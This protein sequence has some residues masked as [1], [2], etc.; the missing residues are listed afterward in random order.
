VRR[1]L[2]RRRMADYCA[3]CPTRFDWDCG[4]SPYDTTWLIPDVPWNRLNPGSRLVFESGAW[5][6]TEFGLELL[7]GVRE[8][9]ERYKIPSDQ[10][11]LRRGGVYELPVQV[12]CE[13]WV[14]PETFSNFE[15]AYKVTLEIHCR[16]RPPSDG[17]RTW[18][19][20]MISDMR[21]HPE[22]RRVPRRQNSA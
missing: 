3:D 16:K 17:P 13:A 21:G 14:G 4:P 2:H 18:L 15:E 10:L 22:P 1:N 9:Y 20:W 5:V 11:L 6:V 19:E 7:S 8:R 12:A